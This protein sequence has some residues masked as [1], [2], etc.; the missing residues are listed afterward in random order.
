MKIA[1]SPEE[2]EFSSKSVVTIGS[3][4]GMHL[5]HREIIS[6]VLGK[7]RMAG[8]RSVVVTFAPHP[9]EVVGRGP[10]E[11]LTTLDERLD[12]LRAAGVDLTMVLDFTYE[13]SRQPAAEF[14]ERYILRGT[15]VKDVVVGHDHA[16]GRDREA[17]ISSLRDLGTREGFGVTIIGPV[18][19]DGK[20]VSS[21]G[22]RALLAGGR[23]AEAGSF[24]GRPYSLTGKVV[25]GD[26]RGAMIGFPTANITPVSPGKIVPGGGVYLV[27]ADV[28][29]AVRHGMLNIGTRPTFVENG[30]VVV[31]LHLLD[32]DET[33]TGE[34]L[35]VRFLRF[36]REEKKFSNAEMLVTQLQRDRSECL[37]YLQSVH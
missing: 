24:L 32:W 25:P 27:E 15:G 17:S 4:D 37:R 21:S 16:F 31:E 29:G 36:I 12:L 23:V 11:L 33:I 3:F 7:A 1:R 19:V 22:I 6:G 2:V 5:G 9:R 14:Y 28:R 34:E 8:G 20:R 30:S 18:T 13:F 10:V 35:T 26:G